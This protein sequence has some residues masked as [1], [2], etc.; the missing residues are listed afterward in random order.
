MKEGYRY[1]GKRPE[2]TDE[3]AFY[4]DFTIEGVCWKDEQNSKLSS[5]GVAERIIGAFFD[6]VERQ[7][8][9]T[10]KDESD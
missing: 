3:L 4:P 2:E 5:A 8:V 10:D 9:V 1:D 7:D 6:A